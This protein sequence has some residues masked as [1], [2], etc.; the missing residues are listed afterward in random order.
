M[1]LATC[2]TVFGSTRTPFGANLAPYGFNSQ[3]QVD[4]QGPKLKNVHPE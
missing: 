3:T 4:P 1:L 2:G